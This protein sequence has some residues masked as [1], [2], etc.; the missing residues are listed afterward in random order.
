MI[1]EFPIAVTDLLA[2]GLRV[3]PRAPDMSDPIEPT[4]RASCNP[5]AWIA[6]PI[7]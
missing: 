1:F 4:V 5:R 2:R 6:Q 7:P 3:A